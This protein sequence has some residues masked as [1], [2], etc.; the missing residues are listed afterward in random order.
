MVTVL[1]KTKIITQSH[2][3]CIFDHV[4]QTHSLHSLVLQKQKKNKSHKIPSA[5]ANS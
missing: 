4:V 5:V 3:T 1:P 2:V